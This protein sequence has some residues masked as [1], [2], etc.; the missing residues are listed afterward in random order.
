M[1]AVLNFFV[2]LVQQPSLLVGL[3]AV[4][5]LLLQKK[6]ATDVVQGGVK[7]FAGFLIRPPRK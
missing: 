7:T 1:K 3:L 5:G 4:L 2:S 6:K